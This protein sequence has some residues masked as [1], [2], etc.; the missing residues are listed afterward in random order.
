MGRHTYLDFQISEWLLLHMVFGNLARYQLLYFSC[1]V[2]NKEFHKVQKNK[3]DLAFM[4]CS[5]GASLKVSLL[6]FARTQ[7]IHS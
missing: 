2:E 3:D 6:S 4:Y 1:I 5:L 7:S